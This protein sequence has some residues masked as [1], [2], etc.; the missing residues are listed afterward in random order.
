MG[1]N[2]SLKGRFL[3]IFNNKNDISSMHQCNAAFGFGLHFLEFRRGIL[4]FD[5]FVCFFIL[6]E[7]SLRKFPNLSR[8]R[9]VKSFFHLLWL[10]PWLFWR[11]FLSL[12]LN[13]CIS[14]WTIC[15]VSFWSVPLIKLSSL[16][17][18][19]SKTDVVTNYVKRGKLLSNTSKLLEIYWF[20]CLTAVFQSFLIIKHSIFQTHKSSCVLQNHI[21]R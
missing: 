9:F 3:S 18:I 15:Q 8:E 11:F 19:L 12:V 21:W 5:Y 13:V 20:W 2:D 4:S 17:K 6:I 7:N 16:R 10:L 14:S 1:C